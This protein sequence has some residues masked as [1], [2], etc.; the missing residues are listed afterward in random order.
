M[1]A[2]QVNRAILNTSL[3][4]RFGFSPVFH[5]FLVPLWMG[6]HL[7]WLIEKEVLYEFCEKTGTQGG[8]FR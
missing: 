7:I 5:W 1:G 3:L 8:K 2:V 4:A 6:F